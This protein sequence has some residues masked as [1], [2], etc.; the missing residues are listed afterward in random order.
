MRLGTRRAHCSA[1]QPHSAA[2]FG[3]GARTMRNA[4]TSQS[5][6]GTPQRE[7]RGHVGDDWRALIKTTYC[8]AGR[9]HIKAEIPSVQPLQL[10]QCQPI[11]RRD[12]SNWLPESTANNTHSSKLHLMTISTP[13]TASLCKVQCRNPERNLG[14]ENLKPAS[15]CKVQLRNLERA[16]TTVCASASECTKHHDSATETEH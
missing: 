1:T 6:M 16:C 14:G 8:C 2:N 13:S 4:A 9:K 5:A 3:G 7:I 11:V 12:C 10:P 15:L